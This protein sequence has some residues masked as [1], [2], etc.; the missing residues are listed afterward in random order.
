MA[1]VATVKLKSPLVAI[2]AIVAS[3]RNNIEHDKDDVIREVMLVKSDEFSL[4]KMNKI[5]KMFG[6]PSAEKL[7][8]L[9][10]DSGI[11]ETKIMNMIDKVSKKCKICCRFKRKESRPKTCLARSRSLNEVVSLDLKP[12]TTILNKEEDKRQILYMIDEFSRFINAIVIKNK[13]PESV[14]KGVLDAW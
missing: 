5:H 3:W 7:K 13:E 8:I 2:V 9:L 6:H 1:I 11:R 12:V 10:K 4:E 14:V